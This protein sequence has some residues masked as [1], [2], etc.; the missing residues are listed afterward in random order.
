MKN[1]VSN[2]KNI[3]IIAW[4]IGHCCI[5][6]RRK[7][8]GNV[9]FVIASDKGILF[10]PILPHNEMTVWESSGVEYCI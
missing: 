1:S 2:I 5:F 6:T 4:L 9:R 7:W 3:I 10:Q 8:V